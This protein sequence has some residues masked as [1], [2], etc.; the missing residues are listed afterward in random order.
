MGQKKSPEFLDQKYLGSGKRFKSAVNKYGK[1]NFTVEL[2]ESCN[3]REELNSKE[4]YWIAELNSRDPDI[5]YNL[6]EGGNYFDNGYHYGMKG[7]HQSDYQKQLVRETA[8]LR[9]ISLNKPEIRLK[10]SNSAKLRTKNRVTNNNHVGIHKGTEFKMIKPEE[11]QNYLN[12]GWSKGIPKSEEFKNDSKKRY[13]TG[14]YINKDGKVKFIQ[15]KDLEEYITDGWK[16]GKK[17]KNQYKSVH[18]KYF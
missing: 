9:K 13:S 4:I 17:P 16:L 8:Y 3:S 5:G 10:L 1:D 18:H 11:L 15:N 14:S 2:L 12:S 7:K 6:A